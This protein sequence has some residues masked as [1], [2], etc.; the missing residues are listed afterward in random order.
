MC[1]KVAFMQLASCWG[2][3]QSLID[4]HLT[5]LHVLPELDIVYWPAVVDFKLHDL[6][7]YKDGSVDVGFLEG[8]CRTEQDIENVH[9]MRKKC[10][11][12][13]AIGACAVLG[14]CPGMAN[15]FEIEELLSSGVSQHNLSTGVGH[16]YPNG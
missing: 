10:K 4:A 3:N 13:V 7:G 5:L 2:C 1:A 11:I 14:G 12:I 9:L 6:E 16:H 15:L 8:F